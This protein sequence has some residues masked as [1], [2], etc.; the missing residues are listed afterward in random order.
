MNNTI[1]VALVGAGGVIIGA[2]ITSISDVVKHILK[3]WPRKK[4]EN[5]RKDHLTKM[6]ESKRFKNGSTE[7]KGRFTPL[8]TD[9]IG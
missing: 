9:E 4:L 7:K 3:N 1:T 6:L 2:I 5:K 8:K